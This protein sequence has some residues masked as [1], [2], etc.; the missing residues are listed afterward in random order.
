MVPGLNNGI[1]HDFRL[2]P[3]R[4]DKSKRDGGPNN[5]K[6][7]HLF[8]RLL[9]VIQGLVEEIE[10]CMMGVQKGYQ[11][12]DSTQLKEQMLVRLA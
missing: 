2:I 9:T 1:V 11:Y 5:R 4:G 10:E 8:G 12:N 6:P 3:Q 7:R